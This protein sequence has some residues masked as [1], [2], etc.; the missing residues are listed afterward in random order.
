MAH[1]QYLGSPLQ[2]SGPHHCSDVFNTWSNVNHQ[3]PMYLLV[4]TLVGCLEV[5]RSLSQ[6]LLT[7]AS[8]LFCPQ[9]LEVAECYSLS[10][11]TDNDS[12]PICSST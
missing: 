12:P 9:L 2:G 3:Y 10:A 7:Y 1:L 8:I 5:E 4:V 11:V 6:V